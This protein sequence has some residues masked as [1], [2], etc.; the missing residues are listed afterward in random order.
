MLLVMLL[1]ELPAR[2]AIGPDEILPDPAMEARHCHS[3]TN[4]NK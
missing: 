1:A 3:P 2:A 4:Q